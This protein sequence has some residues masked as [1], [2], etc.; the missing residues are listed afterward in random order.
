MPALPPGVHVYTD[1]EA[2]RHGLPADLGLGT[3]PPGS[4]PLT[5]AP[6]EAVAADGAEDQH[7][8]GRSY[9]RKQGQVATQCLILLPASLSSDAHAWLGLGFFFLPTS[10]TGGWKEE[11]EELETGS[12]AAL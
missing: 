9:T 4:P 5:R 10:Q 7:C 8:P 3:A 11:G 2:A 6:S 1:H 12:G